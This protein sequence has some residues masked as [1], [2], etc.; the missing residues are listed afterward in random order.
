MDTTTTPADQIDNLWVAA[1]TTWPVTYSLETPH[2]AVAVVKLHNLR[3]FAVAVHT[4][5]RWTH[6]HAAGNVTEALSLV[7]VVVAVY[8][9]PGAQA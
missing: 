4:D 1:N 3:G 6:A 9:M 8:L 5:G 7:P 2:H